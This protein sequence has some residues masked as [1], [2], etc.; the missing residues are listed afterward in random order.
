[1][2]GINFNWSWGWFF[3]NF[4]KSFCGYFQ[5]K[6]H[7]LEPIIFLKFKFKKYLIIFDSWQLIPQN[8]NLSLDYEL[9]WVANNIMEAEL[10]KREYEMKGGDII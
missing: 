7:E 4:S 6:L 10:H 2:C 3:E 1:M 8:E 9:I 5:I